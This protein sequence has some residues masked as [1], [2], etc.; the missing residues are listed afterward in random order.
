MTT[1]TTEQTTPQDKAL[2]IAEA[3]T[4]LQTARADLLPVQ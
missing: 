4:A 3:E 2:T 1:M